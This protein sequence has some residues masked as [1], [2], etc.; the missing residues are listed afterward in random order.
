[1]NV[2][3]TV[4]NW[5]DDRLAGPAPFFMGLLLLIVFTYVALDINYVQHVLAGREIAPSKE[6]VQ[7]SR[8]KPAEVVFY[9]LIGL[10]ASFLFQPHP[11]RSLGLLPWGGFF[12]SLLMIGGLFGAFSSSFWRPVFCIL[13]GVL[14][15][16][17]FNVGFRRMSVF[18]VSQWLTRSIDITFS[19][20][21]ML[22]MLAMVFLLDY[23]GYITEL[24]RV[25]SAAGFLTDGKSFTTLWKGVEPRAWGMV[26]LTVIA[27]FVT[28][29]IFRR[30]AIEGFLEMLLLPF[31]RFRIR[32][33]GIGM[34]PPSGPVLIVANHA[35]WLD[36]FWIGKIIPR[37]IFPLMGSG[38]YDKPFIK[39]ILRDVF[40]VI[41]LGESERRKEL[42]PELDEVV[43]YL[44]QGRCVIIFPEG[45]MRK[46]EE[47]LIRQFGQGIWHILTKRPNTQ[48]VPMWIEGNWG[49]VL[50]YKGGYPGFHKGIDWNRKITIVMGEPGTVS[51]EVLKQHQ[52]TRRFL[53]DAVLELRRYLPEAINSYPRETPKNTAQIG[54]NNIL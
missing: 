44:D 14:W 43:N 26:G 34:L 39:P 10:G 31:Y 37:Q 50:S 4:P 20:F 28:A 41:R 49:S 42:P 36:P 30:E 22:M 51:T 23:S 32:G 47:D 52:T 24:A 8:P 21:F 40:Q 15:M 9:A 35:A 53:M 46:K 27:T 54:T 11:W 33:P 38:F 29:Y 25:G 6:F 13:M 2:G 45:Q 17:P 48:V 3:K 5:R 18:P 7:L 1:M 12:L 19:I 16:V